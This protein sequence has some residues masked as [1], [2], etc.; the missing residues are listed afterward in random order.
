MKF[1]LLILTAT[2]HHNKGNGITTWQL[3]SDTVDGNHGNGERGVVRKDA[4]GVISANGMLETC[5]WLEKKGSPA[6]GV[7]K[8]EGVEE[9]EG[10][11]QG[12]PQATEGK[13]EVGK[14]LKEGKKEGNLKKEGEGEQKNKK[15][16]NRKEE[17]Q[18]ER[19]FQ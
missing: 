3:E 4:W 8:E 11:K 2:Q 13:K 16:E 18:K 14:N 19:K 5:V 6:C 12:R 17:V 15:E 7:G 1:V 9:K 10:E